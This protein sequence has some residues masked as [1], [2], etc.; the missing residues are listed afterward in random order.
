MS[1][2]FAQALARTGAQVRSFGSERLVPCSSSLLNCHAVL[3]GNPTACNVS[4]AIAA[5]FPSHLIL[6]IQPSRP[7]LP[8]LPLESSIPMLTLNKT[9]KL[10]RKKKRKRMGERVSLRM[11]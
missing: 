4:Q 7:S 10:S 11:R 2:R 1:L 9:N 6:G 8:Q 3:Q 5:K